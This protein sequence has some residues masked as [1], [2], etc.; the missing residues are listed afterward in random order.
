[1]FSIGYRIGYVEGQSALLS[2]LLR[3]IES[4]IDLLIDQRSLFVKAGNRASIKVWD[5]KIEQ[6]E[7]LRNRTI[8]AHKSTFSLAKWTRNL[9]LRQPV[10]SIN[11]LKK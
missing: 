6:W 5:G 11:P 9:H 3:D 1:M 10:Q 8:A 4:E 7:G 2:Q